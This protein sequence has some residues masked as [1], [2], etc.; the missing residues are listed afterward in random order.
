MIAIGCTGHGDRRG[1]LAVRPTHQGGSTC[2]DPLCLQFLTEHLKYCISTSQGLE[3]AKPETMRFVL[4][5]DGPDARTRCDARKRHDGG[6]RITGPRSNFVKGGL[7]ACR[8]QHCQ[9][10][11]SEV[12]T[13]CGIAGMSGRILSGQFEFHRQCPFNHWDCAAT[14]GAA[15]RYVHRL[16]H[17]GSSP[18]PSEAPMAP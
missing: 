15:V 11:T 13:R 1:F 8:V 5:E 7:H 6:R 10:L 16:C 14:R 17:S 4:V 9:R 18:V 3:T 2:L 12:G